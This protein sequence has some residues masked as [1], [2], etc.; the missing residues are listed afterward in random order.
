MLEY[1]KYISARRIRAADGS[2]VSVA[3][4]QCVCSM[5]ERAHIF[6]PDSVVFARCRD[7]LEYVER[8]A[9]A[10]DGVS[11]R[12]VERAH[13]VRSSNYCEMWGDVVVWA[14][15]DDLVAR[16]LSRYSDHIE[17]KDV[18][19]D[20]GDDNFI[21]DIWTKTQRLPQSGDWQIVWSDGCYR[22]MV[23][24]GKS[25][26]FRYRVRLGDRDHDRPHVLA[27]HEH[28]NDETARIYLGECVPVG[29]DALDVG[30]D[31]SNRS[32]IGKCGKEE[33]FEWL[34]SKDENG[35]TNWQKCL[36]AWET[37]SAL[38]GGH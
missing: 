4:V 26:S 23:T 33:I 31:P 13:M 9:L 20:A 27:C 16:A 1:R 32:G 22:E 15:S 24:V 10:V 35:V 30:A 28:D 19:E 2:S 34:T 3:V 18:S 5:R 6:N 29:A 38:S 8:D 17:F 21:L 36:D 11:A 25:H 14:A 37:V 7:S 12:T